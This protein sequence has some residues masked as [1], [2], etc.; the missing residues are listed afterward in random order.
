M[1]VDQHNVQ[2]T[3]ET[4]GRLND[5]M[6]R[7]GTP[8]VMAAWL[9]MVAFKLSPPNASTPDV[10]KMV[11]TLQ[12]SWA[13]LIGLGVFLAVIACLIGIP[14]KKEIISSS[15]AVVAGG[16]LFVALAIICGSQGLSF[17]WMLAGLFL[18]VIPLSRLA[19]RSA[20]NRMV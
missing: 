1:S 20:A 12:P 3:N 6:I 5:S 19:Y 10:Q 17:I 13:F 18:L 14:S 16:V 8:L 7:G 15:A 4:T 2:D 9:Y 11:D